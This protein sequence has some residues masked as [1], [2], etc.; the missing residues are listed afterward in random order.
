MLVWLLEQFGAVVEPHAAGDSRVYLTARAAAAAITAFIAAIVLGPRAIDWLRDRFREN[1]NSASA[2]L[3]SLHEAKSG[4]PTMGGLFVVAATVIATF[5]CGNL[6]SPYTILATFILLGFGALGAADDWAKAHS[7]SNRGRGLTARRKLLWQCG[8]AGVAGIGLHIVNA[9]QPAGLWLIWP[10]GNSGL[11]L[12]GL[13]AAW[14]VLVLVGSSN[15]VNLTDGLDGLAGGCLVIAGVAL[16]A[17]CYL[18]GHSGLAAYLNIAYLPGC[19]EL[20]VVLAA[21]V[22]AV[23]G[24]LWFNCHPAQVF[25]GDTGSLPLGGLLGLAALAARQEVLLVVVGGVF[26]VET[27]SVMLQVG[28]YKATGTRVIACSPLHNHFV[29]RGHP[30][31]KVVVRFWIG[32]VLLALAAVASLKIR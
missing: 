26:V 12:G 11:Y 25:M 20:C 31:H 17:L 6:A 15:G 8:I 3:D 9:P 13:F 16:T 4:T 24:F 30:E 19:G 21:A 27:L 22:G 7:S 2:N 29:L 18:A 10:I 5:V 28:V 32:A 1:V 14:A 23:L